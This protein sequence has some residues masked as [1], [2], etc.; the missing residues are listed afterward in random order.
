[1]HPV[2]DQTSWLTGGLCAAS[3][4]PTVSAGFGFFVFVD[5]TYVTFTGFLPLGHS[6]SLFLDIHFS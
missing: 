4:V 1:M 3:V 5:F 2:G 6:F